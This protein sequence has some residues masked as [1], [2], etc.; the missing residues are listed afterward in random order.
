MN[1]QNLYKEI[2]SEIQKD[3]RSIKQI[4]SLQKD[5]RLQNKIIS[6]LQ[7]KNIANK[8]IIS[9][10]ALAPMFKHESFKEEKEWRIVSSL[11]RIMP[12]I[13]FRANES[14]IIPYIE[15]SL[16]QN[17]EEIE[18]KKIFIGPSSINQYSKEAVL[19]LLRRNRIHQNAIRLS[20]APYR[21]A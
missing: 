11:L 18:F 12:D 9:L 6:S 10:F 3:Q 8:F 13:K 1:N 17:E 16:C 2:K 14:N 5:K 21:Y 4:S 19:Q 7:I 20:S 15:I